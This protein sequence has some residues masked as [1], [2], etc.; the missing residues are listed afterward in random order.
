MQNS[1]SGPTQRGDA[2]VVRNFSTS[3]FPRRIRDTG[4]ATLAELGPICV[5]APDLAFEAVLAAASN[6]GPGAAV[7]RQLVA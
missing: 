4:G 2:L 7:P 3:S 5:A 6:R 1:R